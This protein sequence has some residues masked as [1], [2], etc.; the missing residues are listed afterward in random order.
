[1]KG[2][3]GKVLV[4][5]LTSGKITVEEH[6]DN[7]WR[8]HLGGSML[9]VYYALRDIPAGADPL[10]PDNVLTLAVSVITGAPV[11]GISR[12]S[13]NAKS[14]LTGTIGDAQCGGYFAPELKYAGFEAVVV[15][16]K[17]EKP[18]YLW[19][20]DDEYEIRDA[21]ALW[22]LGTRES[23]AAIRN[24]L[25]DDKIRVAG[26][27][28][29]GE[30]L[31]KYACVINEGRHSAG[32]TGMGA[33][34]GSKNLKAVAVRGTKYKNIEY[35][36][37]DAIKAVTASYSDFVKKNAVAEGMSMFGTNG[38][39]LGMN[40]EG[41]LP[42]RNFAEGQFDKGESIGAPAM[43]APPFNAKA[44]RCHVCP[45]A[46]KREIGFDDINGL[47]VDADYGGP[48]YETI[49]MLGSNLLVG[50]LAVIC[51]LH[52]LCNKHSID[53][54]SLGGSIAF[55]MEC[56]EN[57]ILTDEQCG[58]LDISFGNADVLIPLTEKI[59]NREGFIGNL[60]AE[61]PK[62]AAEILGNGAEKYA[63]H[64]KGSP[65]P[66]HMPQIKRGIGVHYA[67]NPFGADHISSDHDGAYSPGAMELFLN[68]FRG[69]GL[70]K[71][72]DISDVGPE[73]MRFNYE[74]QK[75][76]RVIDSLCCCL[77][78]YGTVFVYYLP[79][80]IKIVNGVTGWDVTG[81]ELMY[82][83]ERCYNMMRIFNQREGFTRKDDTLPERMFEPFKGGPSKGA[84]IPKAEFEAALNDYYQI[85]G[86]DLE[87]GNP[88]EGKIKQLGLQEWV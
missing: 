31:V 3:I 5:D 42:T 75:F 79:E 7:F 11:P 30:K 17:S 70:Y 56:R 33:V 51:K 50:D 82:A 35:H 26:I 48:E 24:E 8:M 60:L 2:Y 28:L 61:G 46:C 63:M 6:D 38:G 18:V 1:M 73:K 32:R 34:M 83:G 76:F 13:V 36:D 74:T 57:G 27:G 78:V 10:G 4:A 52:E 19:I 41:S 81:A 47:K 16:G 58:G 15:K 29:G 21:S 43:H 20:H 14:P 54:I 40:A 88:G 64:V 49:G 71:P 23:E 67:L 69:I 44:E 86:W 77:F 85:A 62:I 72:I 22:G 12:F 9:G 68:R 55:A 65:L 25:G 80:L 84:H 87:T 59:I 66:A 45:M 53:P 39:L 37:P